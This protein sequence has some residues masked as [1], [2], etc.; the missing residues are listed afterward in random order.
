MV[1]AGVSLASL[2]PSAATAA[3]ALIGP[4]DWKYVALCCISFAFPALSVN[5]K[6]KIFQ[7]AK[8]QLGGRDL[9]VLVVNAY[10]STA[11]VRA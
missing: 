8:K 3:T 5:I 7:D 6:Q 11:Q 10:G 4:G 9:D 1:V 2:P